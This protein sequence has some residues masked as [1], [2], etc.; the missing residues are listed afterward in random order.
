MGMPHYVIHHIEVYYPNSFANKPE[1]W[2][3]DDTADVSEENV[4]LAQS[5]FCLFSIGP[6]G[7][8]C[9]EAVGDEGAYD[10]GRTVDMVVRDEDIEGASVAR[11][12]GRVEWGPTSCSYG[13]CLL[14]RIS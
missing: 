5:A 13:T 8:A 12:W 11:I 3:V 1:R 6:R 4:K 10:S 2:I 7:R 14:E 9:G